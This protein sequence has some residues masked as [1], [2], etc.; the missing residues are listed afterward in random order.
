MKTRLPIAIALLAVLAAGTSWAFGSAQLYVL[1]AGLAGSLKYH[2]LFDTAVLAIP[3][4]A[5]LG[6][7]LGTFEDDKGHTKII[8]GK[9]ERHDELMFFQHWSHAIG[10]V[11]LIITGLGLGTLFIPRTIQSVENI[12]FAM[13]MHFIGILLFFV[14]AS[15][16]VTK[17]LLTGE[18]KHMLP[19]TGDTNSMIGHYKAM[20]FGGEAPKEEKF[21]SA[22]RVVFPMWIIG[23]SGITLSGIVKTA[24]H[25]WSLPGALTGFFTFLHGVFAIYMALLLV[26]HVTAAALLPASW[27]LIKSMVTGYVT[28]K[29]YHHHVKW[30]EELQSQNSEE[31]SN[32]LSQ[33]A[34]LQV[35]S[36]R[37]K[38]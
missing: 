3:V 33:D 16:Y 31:N 1:R 12:G 26:G 10:T 15:Y 9:I 36:T 25:V 18:I 20:L 8:N 22:E 7:F 6:V 14:G 2:L 17:G 4:A 34:E 5:L 11:I 30:Y 29:Y 23:A 19:K 38:L 32:N 27:P 28:E 35:A 37:I 21:L 24:A 13:N